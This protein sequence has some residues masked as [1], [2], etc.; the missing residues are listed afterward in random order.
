MW[1]RRSSGSRSSVSSPHSASSISF[2]QWGGSNRGSLSPASQNSP[3]SREEESIEVESITNELTSLSLMHDDEDKSADGGDG[4]D[5]VDAEMEEM[6]E[7]MGHTVVE[8]KDML[9]SK[10]LRVTGNKVDLV[11][12]LLGIE[13][14]R[15]GNEIDGDNDIGEVV[16][17][18]ETLSRCTN[19]TLQSK[20]KSMGLS[21]GGKKDT[22]IK[23][24]LGLEPPAPKEGWD[25]SKDKA[26]LARLLKVNSEDGVRYMT[27]EQVHQLPPFDRWPEHRFKANFLNLRDTVIHKEEIALQ[28]IADF[29]ADLA[30]HP[31]SK[32]TRKGETC[33]STFCLLKWT[34]ELI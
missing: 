20:L 13:E 28:D 30:A 25:K 21:T 8:L 22:L 29:K 32:L 3:F 11:N 14:V 17:S 34:F 4:K 27:A 5:G 31:R 1:N 16:L 6:E 33:N 7:L 15:K 12:R 2:R 9:R 23:R 24:L 10:G 19:K 26:L 18:Y